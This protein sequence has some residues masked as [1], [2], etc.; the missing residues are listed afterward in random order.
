[1]NDDPVFS[2]AGRVAVVTGGMGQ[3]GVVYAAALAGII[4]TEGDPKAG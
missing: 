1:M 4:I 3:L 2:V